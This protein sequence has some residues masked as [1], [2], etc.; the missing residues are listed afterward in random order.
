MVRTRLLV[1]LLALV[2][3]ASLAVASPQTSTAGTALYPD[4]QTVVP[5]KLQLHNAHQRE[6]L[7]FTNGIANLGPGPWQLRP[8]NQLGDTSESTTA[9][10]EI[11]DES[12]EIV[13]SHP[14][15]IF[16]FHPAHN[17]WHVGNVALF[18]VRHALDDGTGGLAG[19]LYTNDRG[20]ST[21]TKVTFCLIDWYRLEG[22][23]PSHERVFW[24]CTRSAMQGISAGWVDQYN[25]AVDGQGIDITGA[26]EGLYYLVST[27]NPDQI[28]LESDYS[29]NT[30]WVSFR[31]LRQS[32]GNA[33]LEL[34]AHSPCGH[35]PGMCGEKKLNR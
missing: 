9:I 31:L 30:A 32:N 1:M 6:L 21:S 3:A 18:E 23:S 22:N 11:L 13:L 8:E 34:I 7:R 4:L 12:G 19:S 2:S 27:A 26:P 20:E 24:D 15:S 10:Q 28:F 5:K 25:Q 29:N 35:H 33:R 16:E 17:H 14:A